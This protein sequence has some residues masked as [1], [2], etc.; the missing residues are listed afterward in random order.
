MHTLGR[1]KNAAPATGDAA[2]RGADQGEAGVIGT[3]DRIVANTDAEA[4]D[5][6]ALATFV[7]A[8]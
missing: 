3:A 6:P 1:V 2:E 4:R 8:R 7:R 5:L